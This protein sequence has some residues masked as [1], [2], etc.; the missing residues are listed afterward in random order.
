MTF[1][2]LLPPEYEFLRNPLNA[3]MVIVIGTLTIFLAGLLI[4]SFRRS[5]RLGVQQ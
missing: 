5:A 3:N 1:S 2:Y 4:T